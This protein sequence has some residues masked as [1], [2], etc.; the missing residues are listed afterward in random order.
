M[1]CHIRI[2]NHSCEGNESKSTCSGCMGEPGQSP[3]P[4]PPP[5][6]CGVAGGGG[7]RAGSCL[8]ILR[9]EGGFSGKQ[10]PRVEMAPNSGKLK[11]KLDLLHV[12]L[13]CFAVAASVGLRPRGAGSKL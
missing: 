4:L 5:P 6:L 13:H 11:K 12:V 8:G 1:L 9:G 2:C 3:A 10:I 7:W